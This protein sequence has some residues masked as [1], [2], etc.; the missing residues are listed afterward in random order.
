MASLNNAPAGYTPP[1]VV[2]KKR[3]VKRET[4]SAMMGLCESCNI[5]GR[6][7]STITRTKQVR[8]HDTYDGMLCDGCANHFEA[9]SAIGRNVRV[10]NH[11]ESNKKMELFKEYKYGLIMDTQ[12]FGCVSSG[13]TVSIDFGDI[14]KLT[15]IGC[16]EN[17]KPTGKREFA[18]MKYT[19][20]IKVGG[21]NL[22]LFPH[23]VMPIPWVEIML[24]RK[25]GDYKECFVSSGDSEGFFS[26]SEEFKNQIQSMYGKR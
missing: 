20:D 22:T 13:N 16:S 5:E 4:S 10:L 19:V 21:E 26:P 1:V 7:A 25:E 14:F 11:I 8:I 18:K 6:L 23:E 3:R 24:M 9:Y 2:V 17:L 15:R 12:S